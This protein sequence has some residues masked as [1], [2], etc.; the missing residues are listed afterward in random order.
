MALATKRQFLVTVSGIPGNWDSSSGGDVTAAANKHYEG[1]N[2][3][4][5]L[6]GGL[7]ETSDLEVTRTFDPVRDGELLIQLRKAVGRGRFTL[8]KQATDANRVKIGK[9]ET[10]PDC[11]LIGVSAPEHEE[12]SADPSPFKL[13]FATAG[14]A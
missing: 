14:A 9:P 6:L 3:R 1:G 11:L 12:G 7:P 2:D 13:T 4:P 8:T 10:H 5:T